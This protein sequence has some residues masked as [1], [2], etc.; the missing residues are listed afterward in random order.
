MKMTIVTDVDGN[1][2]GAVQG[3]CLSEHKDGVEASVSFAPGHATYMVEVDDDMSTI[4]D[5]DEFQQRLRHHLQQHQQQT[6]Q[7][8]P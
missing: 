3:H 1:V 8:Q 5:V 2:L 7:Q 6:Q 4:D